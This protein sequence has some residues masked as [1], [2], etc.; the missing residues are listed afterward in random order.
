MN[1]SILIADDEDSIRE[2][3]TI[4]LE[5]EGYNCTAVKDGGEAIEAID[6]ASYDII[7]TDLKMPDTDGIELL[8]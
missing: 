7:V 1:G 6:K 8:E 3:L 4:V 5:D 2:S